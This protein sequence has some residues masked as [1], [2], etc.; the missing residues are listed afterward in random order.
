M[1]NFYRLLLKYFLNL[2]YAI[3]ITSYLRFLYYFYVKKNFKSYYSD[4]DTNNNLPVKNSETVIQNQTKYTVNTFK[5]FFYNIKHKFN[6]KRSSILIDPLKSIDCINFK[7]A[8]IL[9]IG[10]RLESEIFNLI[11]NGFQKKNISALDL[12]SYSPLIKLGDMH[13]IPFND[14]NFDIVFS[15]WVL[16]YSNE[17]EKAAAEM[18]RTVKNGG[19]IA[20]GISF[21]PDKQFSS[22][23][24]HCSNE[25][26]RY[27][28]KHI[29]TT[30]FSYHP[31]DFINKID[32]E[33]FFRCALIMRIRK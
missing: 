33:K 27:F 21:K 14:N 10:P 9:S 3:G 31:G 25:I 15:G 1:Q 26:K 13:K 30:I 32:Q 29:D 12:Q 18:I 5:N 16:S 6:G 20:I 2:P 8:K 11:K 23:S 28:E 24:L 19:F 22:K 17:I 7:N 4:I